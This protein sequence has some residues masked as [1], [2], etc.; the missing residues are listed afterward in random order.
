MNW[1][2]AAWVP[3]SQHPRGANETGAL[4]LRPALLLVAA[5]VPLAVSYAHVAGMPAQYALFA[6]PAALVGYARY[7]SPRHAVAPNLPT[8]AV[9]AAVVASVSTGHARAAA[10]SAGLAIVVSVVLIAAG[11]ARLGFVRNL[12]TGPAI[13]GFLTGVAAL[14]AL[15]QMPI[16]VGQT[17]PTD[18]SVASAVAAVFD[19][20]GQW[21]WP[22]V[23]VSSATISVLVIARRAQTRVL[24]PLIAL[25]VAIAASVALGLPASGVTTI[26]DATGRAGTDLPPL[27]WSALG[28]MLGPL[29][30]YLALAAFGG[31]PGFSALPQEL[32]LDGRDFFRSYKTASAHA[33]RLLFAAGKAE[34]VD[35]ACRAALVGKLTPEALYVH[36][37]AVGALPALLRVYEGCGR[38]LAGMVEDANV[39]KLKRRKAKVCYLSYPRFDQD[40]HPALVA[41]TVASLPTLSLDVYNYTGVH[42]PAVLHRKETLVATDY[43]LRERFARLT[44]Q[45]ERFGLYESPSAI[46]TR[47][48]WAAVVA[49]AGLRQRGHRLVRR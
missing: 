20:P 36:R 35:V 38:A 39:V 21:S 25:S 15:H 32:Q 2:S 46:G 10:L 1:T 31:R 26:G 23:L 8:A 12:L 40:P 22:T 24:G 9:S 3:F 45:E 13:E 27:E 43:P 41:S 33:D 4:N 7:G 18:L 42:N 49:K 6:A 29:L 28:S 47:D 34:A 44:A 30:V 19:Q 17:P 14:V 48:G 37:S 11:I 16:L 5:T